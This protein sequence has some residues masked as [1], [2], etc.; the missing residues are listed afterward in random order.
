MNYP[1]IIR[2]LAFTGFGFVIAM[3]FASL[4]ALLLGE[5]LQFRVFLTTAV[6]LATVSSATLVM[7]GRPTR[8]AQPSDGLAFMVFFWVFAGL[9]CAPPFLLGL[10]N[11][12]AAAAIHEA[13]SC[14]TTTG[15]SVFD[16]AGPPLPGS[17]LLWRA[18][19]HLA[20]AAATVTF[21]ATVLAALS[22]DGPGIHRTP[23]FSISD[24]SFFDTM[25][26]VLKVTGLFGSICILA[27][28][29]IEVVGGIPVDMA[30][31]DAVSAITTGLVD[32]LSVS[33]DVVRIARVLGLS[34]GLILGSLGIFFMI[35]IANRQWKKAFI[36]AETLSF[37]LALILFSV[38]GVLLGLTGLNAIGWTLSSLSTSGIALVA[39][40][41]T[42]NL[43]LP[44][45]LA[46]CL[47]GGAALSAAGGLKLGRLYVLGRRVGQ[48]FKRMGFRQSLVHFQFRGR[49][50]SDRTLMGIWVYLVAYI[51][52]SV[53][54]L[55]LFSFL[56]LGFDDALATTLGSL[57]N[58]GHLIPRAEIS[59]APLYQV[60][61]IFGM[62]LGRLEILALIP[63]LTVSFWRR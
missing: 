15:H 13:I 59:D 20:G 46:P 30:F 54:G 31:L 10:P 39:E 26:R 48:E 53:I 9:A 45:Q 18:L 22:L 5:G 12:S 43:P 55:L 19:L 60:L 49:I 61:A 41:T 36:D 52:A 62:I 37:G 35:Q 4:V 63:L 3:G 51:M 24:E 33:S 23:L 14:L 29:T 7:V 32:P 1:A 42:G 34:L 28:F 21:A 56:G 58:S 2:M 6:L 57:T 25:P 50:Q 8:R 27:I 44:L 16:P 38:A 47:V 40:E 11:A 17:I